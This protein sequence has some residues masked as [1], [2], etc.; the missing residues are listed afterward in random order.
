MFLLFI[1]DFSPITSSIPSQLMPFILLFIIINIIF[2]KNI[3]FIIRRYLPS[4]YN[5]ILYLYHII[6]T[7]IVI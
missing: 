7:Y 4:Y 6:S 3:V 5:N 1:I 2:S